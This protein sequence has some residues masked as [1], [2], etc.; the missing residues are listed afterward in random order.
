MHRQPNRY[1]N[2]IFRRKSGLLPPRGRRAYAS[3][4]SGISNEAASRA[5]LSKMVSGYICSSGKRFS[6]L[7]SRADNCLTTMRERFFGVV[8]PQPNLDLLLTDAEIVA[9][10]ADIRSVSF[11]PSASATDTRSPAR[12][13]A[14]P[15]ARRKR[16]TQCGDQVISMHGDHCTQSDYGTL[17]Q[18]ER[19]SLDRGIPPIRVAA[20]HWV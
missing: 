15:P 16:F 13:P 11:E 20:L 7:R 2:I 17:S 6:V 18:R 12:P 9:A 8:P 19:S 1:C 10:L 3:S 14:R 4:M 5:S